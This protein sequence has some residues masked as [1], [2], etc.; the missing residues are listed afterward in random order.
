MATAQERRFPAL[1]PRVD[2]EFRASL[3]QIPIDDD[4][5]LQ[6]IVFNLSTT[7]TIEAHVDGRYWSERSREIKSIF[8]SELLVAGGSVQRDI[9]VERGA[10]LN[11]RALSTTSPGCALGDLYFIV[12]I[13]KSLTGATT[14][15][16]TLLQGYANAFSTLAWPGSPIESLHEGKGA[17][18]YPAWTQISPFQIAVTVPAN[19]RWRILTGLATFLTDAAAGDRQVE[20]S[21]GHGG[22]PIYRAEASPPHPASTLRNYAL[23]PGLSPSAVVP[24]RDQLIGF[25]GDFELVA[26]DAVVLRTD[27]VFAS[28]G[29]QL[30]GLG[31]A[32]REWFDPQ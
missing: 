17:I 26:N 24:A 7:N 30:T 28:A 6:V 23:S 5:K 3:L 8:F 21:I 20:L 13:V 2:S 11:L 22:T 32:V 25:V 19:R 29:D 15:R 1:T 12:Q 27:L 10:L 31:F 16:G 9:S 18:R 4:E 14:G